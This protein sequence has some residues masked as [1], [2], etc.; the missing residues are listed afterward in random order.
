MFAELVQ[1]EES[2]LLWI[3]EVIRTPY[4]TPFFI[5]VTRLGDSG[6]IWIIISCILLA[7]QK[8]RKVG[9]IA[10]VALAGSY[11]VNNLVLK[12]MIARTR[13]YEMIP[14][15]GR[16]IEKQ[17]DYSFP[18]GHT[19]SSFA[20]AVVYYKEL[21]KK[22]GFPLMFLAIAIAFSRLYLGVHY[23]SDVII[24]AATGSIIAIIVRKCFYKMERS[25]KISELEKE[26]K[27]K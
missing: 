10:L 7:F 12:N 20:A 16:L 3:Q 24:G 11:L 14:E 18:S 26:W 2:I 4:L 17:S 8:T 21:P 9:A 27:D 25:G 19:G 15:L 13:P 5:F 23:P 22:Y 6:M 1:L